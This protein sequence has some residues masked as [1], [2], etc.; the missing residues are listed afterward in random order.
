M[1][2]EWVKKI[3]SWLLEIIFWWMD[4]LKELTFGLMGWLF[5]VIDKL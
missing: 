4:I 2:N 5:G 3:I 1:L